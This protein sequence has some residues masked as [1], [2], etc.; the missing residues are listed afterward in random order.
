[1]S[2]F[3]YGAL[4]CADNS[5]SNITS[6]VLKSGVANSCKDSSSKKSHNKK[7]K[8]NESIELKLKIR[9]QILPEEVESNA[10]H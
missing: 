2:G 10:G 5:F 4:S 3:K 7:A 6:G 1:M 8:E 9:C